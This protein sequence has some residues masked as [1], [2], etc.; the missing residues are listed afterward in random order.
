MTV[1]NVKI[2]LTLVV[3]VSSDE[4]IGVREA[5]S[6]ADCFFHEIGLSEQRSRMDEVH[7]DGLGKCYVRYDLGDLQIAGEPKWIPDKTPPKKKKK[8]KRT[9]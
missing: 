1:F 8:S 7:V 3:S 6:A 4:E 5:E 2:P 9:T